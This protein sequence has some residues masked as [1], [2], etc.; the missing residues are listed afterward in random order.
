MLAF[1][2][3]AWK[4]P[5]KPRTFRRFYQRHQQAMYQL[6]LELTAS[7]SLAE[8]ATHDALLAMLE[9]PDKLRELAGD[10]CSGRSYA[11][12]MAR[13][14]AV[15]LIR[16]RK[17]EQQWESLDHLSLTAD[18]LPPSP[19]EGGGIIEIIDSLP[20]L[21]SAVLKLRGLGFAPAEIAKLQGK[22][23]QTVYKQ[24]ARG[25][26]LLKEKMKEEGYEYDFPE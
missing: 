9:Q 1:I 4:G 20:E 21:Y 17:R 18:D 11:L 8:D 22:E 7:P 6:A 13:N 2:L 10:D 26:R 14:K 25:K 19:A 16:R 24:L 5:K 12:T 15:D 23:I 3:T